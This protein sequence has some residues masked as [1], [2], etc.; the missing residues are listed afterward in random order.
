MQHMFIPDTGARVLLRTPSAGGTF[1]AVGLIAIGGIGAIAG[2]ILLLYGL[3]APARSGPVPVFV[4]GVIA[5]PLAGLSLVYGIILG[6]N[7]SP[8][9]LETEPLGRG[10]RMARRESP[11]HMNLAVLPIPGGGLASFG[12]QF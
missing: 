7:S 10:E 11:V 3:Y 5:T 4:A 9:V 6:K 12:L 2:P 1:G 8:R